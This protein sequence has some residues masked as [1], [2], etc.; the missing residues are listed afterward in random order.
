MDDTQAVIRSLTTMFLF[1]RW[2][3]RK[4][5]FPTRVLSQP[6]SESTQGLADVIIVHF[7]R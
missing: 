5:P 6:V 3:T 2:T 1:I 4:L 7:Y